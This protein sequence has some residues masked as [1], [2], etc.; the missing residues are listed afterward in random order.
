MSVDEGLS[1]RTNMAWNA[2]GS[3]SRLTCNYLVTIA[4]VRLSH[5]FDAAGALALAMAI[6]NLVL[7]FAEFRLRTI[8]VTD[9]TGERSAG[10]YLGLRLCTTVLSFVAGLVYAHVTGSRQ[11]I[12]VILLYLVYSLVTNLIE[13]FH[14]VDQRHRRMD[15]IGRSYLM[16]GVV[17][18]V[19]FCAG[20]WLT[21][22]LELAVG[23]MALAVA[24]IGLLYD[25][26]RAARFEPLRPQIDLRDGVRVLAS[27]LPLVVAQ[28]CSTAVLAIPRQYLASTDGAAALGIYAS[29][30]APA[31][32]VQMGASYVYS[33]LMSEFA[34]TFHRDK[35]DARRLLRKTTLAILVV[36]G[37]F[38]VL[39]TLLGR[40][41]LSLMY[42]SEIVRYTYLL[43]P[44][45]LCTLTT[46]FA[47]FMND[48]LLALRDFRASFLGNATATAVT[49]LC[50][51]FAVDTFGM[52]GV[53]WGG[54]LSYGVSVLV[55]LGFL[56][57]DYRRLEPPREPSSGGA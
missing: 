29:V 28:V 35:R 46:A 18:L 44:A 3:V 23:L 36:T 56:V 27:L 21:N 11:A 13:G 20:L 17:T 34:E 48:L 26:P 22:S 47:W 19:V 54:V 37:V 50:Y 4:V 5:G 52:N 45:V 10:S 31:I 9:V 53:S 41:I 39:L 51:R 12:V 16:Q 1:L 2:F 30:A 32:I 40:P 24:V 33:P 14:A 6:S 7:P 55:L 43:A 57:R 8:H 25:L 38:A 49:L 15:I 42:G